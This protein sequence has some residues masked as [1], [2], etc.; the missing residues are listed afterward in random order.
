MIGARYRDCTND[1]L[2]LYNSSNSVLAAYSHVDGNQ[3]QS[4]GAAHCS[5]SAANKIY[6]Y[7]D[8]DRYYILIS[9]VIDVLFISRLVYIMGYLYLDCYRFAIYISTVK[10]C[11]QFYFLLL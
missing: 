4:E 11:A 5:K 8:C 3:C 6:L 7:L 10:P 9:T 2:D 1:D